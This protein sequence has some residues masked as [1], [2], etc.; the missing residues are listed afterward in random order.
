M[1]LV[2]H[3]ITSEWIQTQGLKHLFVS[4][5]NIGVFLY[6][7][8]QVKEV[9]FLVLFIYIFF[10]VFLLVSCD[11]NLFFPYN[12]FKFLC[13]QFGVALSFC[14]MEMQSYQFQ[15]I[16]SFYQLHVSLFKIQKIFPKAVHN[17]LYQVDFVAGLLLFGSCEKYFSSL[18]Q[19]HYPTLPSLI[20]AHLQPRQ[21][22]KTISQRLL[23][24]I[25]YT[26]H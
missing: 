12:C 24:A 3:I 15:Q 7:N 18:F 6:R 13:V 5:H 26:A 16:I 25:I 2:K 14:G 11:C 21:G 8:K 20:I 19:F 23:F 9:P 22:T 4:F 10:S 1:H 17:L